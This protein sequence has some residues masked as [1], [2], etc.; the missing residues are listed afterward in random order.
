MTKIEIYDGLDPGKIASSGQCFR[1]RSFRAKQSDPRKKS[2]ASADDVRTYVF[3]SG[4][5]ILHI[6]EVT[7]E[8]ETL[9]GAD[10]QTGAAG[11]ECKT[12]QVFEVSCD[13]TE[14]HSFWHNYFD[15]GRSYRDVAA[16]AKGKSE[17]ADEAAKRGFGL[18]ILRQEPWEMLVTF[19][20]SQRK[21]IPSIAKS[22]EKLAE[23]FGHEIKDGIRS[24]PSP[25]ELAGA[26]ESDLAQCGLGYR[27]GYVQDAVK[28]AVSGELD[29]KTAS[30]L[31][32]DKLLEKLKQVRGVGEKVANCIALFAYARTACAPADVWIN[33][34]IE[35]QF[36]GKSP[37]ALFGDD[38]GII[39]QY[40][41]CYE[42]ELA[43]I[44]AG[45]KIGI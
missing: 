3:V 27:V 20:I 9:T 21:S 12:K 7:T 13:E 34:A 33:R 35:E 14:W 18:R 24:F 39:Q 31:P 44:K 1:V 37:F 2:L 28:K 38:A 10:L 26:S 32:D 19:I 36:G 23:K 11:F 16:R 45:L 25:E 41:F 15:I 6:K 29:L 40:I 43:G 17:F 4:D 8:S 22:V 5:R 30:K 42:R